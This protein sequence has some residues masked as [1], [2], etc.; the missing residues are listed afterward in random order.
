M[1]IFVILPEI[2]QIKGSNLCRSDERFWFWARPLGTRTLPAAALVAASGKTATGISGGLLCAGRSSP[3]LTHHTAHDDEEDDDDA[4]CRIGRQ[5][6]LV[7]APSAAQMWIWLLVLYENRCELELFF[8]QDDKDFKR[9]AVFFITTPKS[10]HF[11][12]F[13]FFLNHFK[14]KSAAF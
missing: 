14:K 5:F 10:P 4:T 2:K 3:S 6:H 9:T 11:F 13:Y 12:L 1:L 8:P 7:A